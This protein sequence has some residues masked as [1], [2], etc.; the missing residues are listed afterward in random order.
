MPRPEINRSA[1]MEV[2][3]QVVAHAGFSAA[4]RALRMTPSAVSKLVARLEARL[5]AR[6]VNRSTRRMQ[7]TAEGLAF[8]DRCQRILADIEEAEREAAAGAAPRGRVRVNAS[9]PFGTHHLLPL[10]P[11]FLERF[12]EVT[13]DIV[14]SDQVIDLLEQRA[15]VAIRVGP[16]RNSQLVARKLGSSAMVVVAAPAYLARHGMP[17][18]LAALT[19]HNLIGF[20]F[21]RSFEEWPFLE[22]GRIATVA[23]CG[24]AQVGDGESARQL[25]LAGVGL[26]RLAHIHVGPDIA[27]GRLVPVLEALNPGDREEIHAIHA[28]Q[29]GRMPSRVRVFIDHLVKAIRLG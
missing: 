1:E 4:A 19:T 14:L 22:D 25:A 3:T 8:H 17:G 21:A 6:L 15:D 13:L 16:L 28:S 29:A 11:G 5:D 2:F 18:S 12:P 27:A 7:L 9:V 10:V 20:N 24:N 23:A 26:A